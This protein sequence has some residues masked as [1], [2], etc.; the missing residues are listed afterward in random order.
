MS[1]VKKY[2]Y[3]HLNINLN[4]N[5]FFGGAVTEGHRAIID[6]HARKGYR[7]VGFIPTRIDPHGRLEELDLVFE[8][9]AEDL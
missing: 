5:L 7:Y 9:D 2:E 1:A 3:V 6:E 4:I 8:T